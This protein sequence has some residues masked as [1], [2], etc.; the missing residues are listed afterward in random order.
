M[1]RGKY[2]V[3]IPAKIRP[4][5]R[6]GIKIIDERTAAIGRRTMGQ[7]GDGGKG[8]ELFNDFDRVFVD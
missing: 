6:D 5:V 8:D 3:F 1:T 2:A 7:K 4:P